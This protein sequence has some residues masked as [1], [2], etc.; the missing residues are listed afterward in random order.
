MGFF[1][2]KIAVPAVSEKNT[3]PSSPES[4]SPHGSIHKQR[5]GPIDPGEEG[6]VTFIAVLLGAISSMGGFMFG[7]ESGQISGTLYSS[8]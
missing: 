7:Y 5:N 1:S 8:C 4:Q 2:R 6:R 3:S